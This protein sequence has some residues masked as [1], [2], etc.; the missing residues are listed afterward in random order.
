MILHELAHAY[1]ILVFGDSNSGIEA[2]Y[3]QAVAS[4]LYE[5]VYYIKGGKRKAYALTNAK[6]YFAELSEAY[7]GKNDFY[8]FTHTQL[9]KHDPVGYQMMEQVWGKPIKTKG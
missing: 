4:R 1:H 9:K 7:F 6:E 8:P 5:S 3:Q 2:V